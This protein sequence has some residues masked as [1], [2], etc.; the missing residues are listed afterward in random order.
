MQYIYQTTHL[1]SSLVLSVSRL[2]IKLAYIHLCVS[3]QGCKS[4]LL[5]VMN[6]H[7]HKRNSYNALLRVCCLLPWPR[8]P[9]LVCGSTTLAQSGIKYR[10]IRFRRWRS[11]PLPLPQSLSPTISCFKQSQWVAWLWGG[12]CQDVGRSVR[13]FSPDGLSLQLFNYSPNREN[14]SD[15]G[16]PLTFLLGRFFF[17]FFF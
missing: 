13:L 7:S 11:W 17:F 15:F 1:L 8:G 4:E 10:E 6:S 5:S 9:M 14:P 16:D 2:S 12:Q 3:F